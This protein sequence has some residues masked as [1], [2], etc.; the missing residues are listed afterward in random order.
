MAKIKI[1]GN[2]MTLTS[3]MK[4]EDIAKAEKFCPEA[5]QLKDNNDDIYFIVK[6]GSP[7]ASKFGVS[8]NETNS[9]GKA[10]MTI[11]GVIR[12]VDT[13]ETIKEDFAEIILNLR[14]VEHQ[15]EELRETLDRK[16]AS[17][18]DAIEIVD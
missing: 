14:A 10:Y 12:D 13:K 3:N 16:I 4:S 1:L 8:F 11:C 5:L 17:V 15:M 18:N 7:S 2:A 6:T 9:E